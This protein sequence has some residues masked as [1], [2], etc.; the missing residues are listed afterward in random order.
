MRG[1]ANGLGRW[2]IVGLVIFR[3]K[4]NWVEP[5]LLWMVITLRLITFYIPAHYA[6]VYVS[7]VDAGN[8]KLTS[9]Q[10]LTIWLAQWYGCRGKG[11]T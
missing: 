11:H 5:M 3:H 6:L 10:P 2:W 4:Y 8:V 1:N 9:F 7:S